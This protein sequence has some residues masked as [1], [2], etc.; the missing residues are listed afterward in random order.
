M[1]S[2]LKGAGIGFEGYGL[3]TVHNVR[4][5]SAA[6]AAEGMLVRR[7]SQFKS[8]Y[9]RCHFGGHAPTIHPRGEVI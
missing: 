4:K 9:T 5:I 1:Y 7:A 2:D 8:E 6:L 3:Q